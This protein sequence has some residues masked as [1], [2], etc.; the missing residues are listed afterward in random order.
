MTALRIKKSGR[1]L[2]HYCEKCKGD[3]LHLIQAHEYKLNSV[4][5]FYFCQTCYVK[6]E[7]LNKKQLT[8]DEFTGTVGEM[9]NDKWNEFNKWADYS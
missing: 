2:H 1:E 9:N 4:I 6:W 5:Y 8:T 7:V 3:E